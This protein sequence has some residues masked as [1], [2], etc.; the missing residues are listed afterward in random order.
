VAA[1]YNYQQYN[2][3][4]A[5]AWQGRP[6]YY[7]LPPN[8]QF[9]YGYSIP[10]VQTQAPADI[11]ADY[12]AIKKQL[13]FYFGE[14]NLVRDSFLRNLMNDEGFVDSVRLA[15]FPRMRRGGIRPE[16][17]IIAAGMSKELEIKEN[18]VRSKDHWSHF[19]NAQKEDAA[20]PVDPPTTDPQTKGQDAGKADSLVGKIVE[21]DGESVPSEF[22]KK[23][24]TVLGIIDQ[25]EKAM[26]QMKDNE[27]KCAIVPVAE[28]ALLNVAEESDKRERMARPPGARSHGHRG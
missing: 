13:E 7:M 17:I 19:I 1:Y 20:L 21:A 25:G 14:T 24:C 18:A 2:Y 27:N 8:Y 9:S 12:V 11:P 10:Y 26:V 23:E 3:N 5:A 6:Q 15:Q 22:K 16:E 4:A 28:L